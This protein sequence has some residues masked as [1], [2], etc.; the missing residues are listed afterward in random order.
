VSV[1]SW[2]RKKFT[3][4]SEYPICEVGMDEAL[5]DQTSSP[6]QELPPGQEPAGVLTPEELESLAGMWPPPNAPDTF[7]QYT[8]AKPR[9]GAPDLNLATSVGKILFGPLD[10]KKTTK[11]LKITVTYDDGSEQVVLE[12]FGSIGVQLRT[13]EEKP[14]LLS[15]WEAGPD[16]Q[17]VQCTDVD[18]L[19]INTLVM[20]EQKFERLSDNVREAL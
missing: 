17:M 10:P 15:S 1:L 6:K 19:N 3:G 13:D 18:Y 5:S 7:G 20:R 14:P 16:V 8:R 9:P 2:F 12:R 4:W 11:S